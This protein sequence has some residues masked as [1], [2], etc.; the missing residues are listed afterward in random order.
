MKKIITILLAFAMLFAF[1]ACDPVTDSKPP[2]NSNSGTG[3]NQTNKDPFAN[4]ASTLT[5]PVENLDDIDFTGTWDFMETYSENEEGNIISETNLGYV[6][7]TN[8]TASAIYTS[9]AVNFIC[10][11]DETY[12]SGKEYYASEE[13]IENEWGPGSTAT[14]NNATK[15]ITIIAG[16]ETLEEQSDETEITLF[17]DYLKNEF[18][19]I[20]TNE[21]KTALQFSYVEE[22]FSMSFILIKR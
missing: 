18:N 19:T 17:V 8:E 7:V 13:T 14:F 16:P 20:T 4:I 6:T 2:V 15:T 9:M 21:N 1:V 10:K 3:N 22:G 5:V 12:L 11:D